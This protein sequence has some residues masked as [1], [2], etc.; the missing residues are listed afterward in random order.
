MFGLIWNNNS[1]LNRL[2]NLLINEYRKLNFETNVYVPFEAV[3]RDKGTLLKIDWLDS[4]CGIHKDTNADVLYTDIYDGDGN[5]IAKDFSK[6]YLSALIS[7]LTFILPEAVANERKFLK[8]IDLLDFPGARSREK[9]KEQQLGEV[10][11]TILRRG[12]VAYLF[13]KYSRS[14]KISAVLFCHHNDQKTEPTI[15][16]TINN[17]IEDNI[18]DTPE[19]RAKVL[20]RTNG[21]A[22]LFLICTKFNIDLERTKNDTHETASKLDSHWARFNTT[23]PKI[24]A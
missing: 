6:A 4:V 22:P 11:P 15:G 12:K 13:N 2:F 5:I 10:L 14:F 16:A 24:I 9:I 17:W 3:L 8:K 1:E 18:G 7:E 20:S 19:K 23:L 21:I